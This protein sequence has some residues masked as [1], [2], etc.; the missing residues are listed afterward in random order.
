M[1]TARTQEVEHS[2]FVIEEDQKQDN[3]N[4]D[5]QESPVLEGARELG[6][7]YLEARVQDDFTD[8]LVEVGDGSLSNVLSSTHLSRYTAKLCGSSLFMLSVIFP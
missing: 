1:K 6:K 8:D 4:G 2:S 3:Q 5:Y 7:I